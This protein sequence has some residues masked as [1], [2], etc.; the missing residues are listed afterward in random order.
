MAFQQLYYTS[1]EHGLSGFSGFQ[2]NAVTRGVSPVVMREVED[3]TV[4]EPPRWPR[5]GPRP[6]EPSA[7]PVTFCY[8]TSDATG[9]V[10]TAQVVFAGTDYSGRPGNY[11]AHALV[12]VTPAR[13]F[14]SLLPVELW[15]AELWRD[16]PA[17]STELPELTGP[18][19][20]GGIDRADT[21]AFLDAHDAAG[22]LPQLVTAVGKAMA[23]DRPVLLASNDV[24]DGA[25]WIAAV[26]YLLGEHL[27]PR[28][29][30]T[31][32][33]HRPT[34][35]RYH[36]TGVLP[37][38]LPPDA[39]RSF[40]LFD[41]TTGQTPGD[42]VHP[43][44]A[45]LADTG[46]TAS[47]EL[48]RQATEFGPGAKAGFD[49]W[50]APVTA[51]AG[52]LGRPLSP[53]ETDEVARW[54]LATAGSMPPPVAELALGIPLSQPEGA[55]S[56]RR[57][58]ELQA[59]TRRLPA[60][61]LA[62]RL[63]LTLVERSLSRLAQGQ[64]AP[65]VRLTDPDAEE[66]A[67]AR[68]VRLLDASTPTAALAVVGWAAASGLSLPDRELEAYGR[69]RLDPRVPEPGLE[70]LL[71][72]SPA[73]RRGLLA[74][75]ASEPPAVAE[76]LFGGPADPPFERND[77]AE[78]PWLTE[79]WLIHAATHGTVPPLRAF[80]EICDVRAAT[81]RSP[82]VDGE[83]LGR[84]WPHGCP[85]AQLAELLQ[86]VT[87]VP[88]TDVLAWLTGEISTVLA[89]H[90]SP[91]QLARALEGHPVLPLLPEADQRAIQESAHVE[92]LVDRARAAVPSGDMSVFGGLFSAYAAADDEG[93][94]LLRRDLS[95]LLA[96][97]DPLGGA[98]RDCP[99][100]AAAAFCHELANWLSPGRA[101]TGLARRV[102]AALAHPDV[103]RRPALVGQLRVPLERVREWHRRDL[104][105][106]ARALEQDGLG[107]PFQDWRGEQPAG[108][109]R[110]LFGV[111]RRRG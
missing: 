11:F 42:V 12:T 2:F 13:D 32:Y 8:G 4:Y 83:L 86:A 24:N 44:A 91:A 65:A 17:D 28:M 26:S 59:L 90:G 88:T 66:N 27:A 57:L 96:V 71:R 50:L 16:R 38:V 58:A 103:T 41:L 111:D 95:P 31:T 102:F 67:R 82:R 74:R 87:G 97:A 108:L 51:A 35:T 105:D 70:R 53:D 109:A 33:T 1:C 19:R 78:H 99:E 45:I 14:G 3:R 110:R 10:I 47:S 43:L 85:P 39:G 56:D 62:V 18:L 20:R 55:L 63:E 40:Q 36:L 34:R 107:R 5:A 6:E 25:W 98:L 73:V 22:I 30:F 23:G 94:R 92:L 104:A 79:L 37:E 52:L 76:A 69:T 101:D 49:D 106:L 89:G 54:L 9:A 46:V 61:G 29:T 60:P 68:A 77:L 100:E 72:Q 64:W 15:R 84:L 75:L 81:G 48:W 80:D 7:Y 21:Q 93:R